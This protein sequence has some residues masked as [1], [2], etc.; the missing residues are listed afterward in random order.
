[1]KETEY[2]IDREGYKGMRETVTERWGELDRE[3]ERKRDLD[4]EI[5]RKRDLDRE[6]GRM[7]KKKGEI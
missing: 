3:I 6:I 1:M 5:E 7:R 2:E 4:R